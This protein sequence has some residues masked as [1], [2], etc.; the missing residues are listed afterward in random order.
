MILICYALLDSS[1]A[2]PELHYFRLTIN[3]FG[4][5]HLRRH[6]RKTFL[7]HYCRYCSLQGQ[8]K[9]GMKNY[10]FLQTHFSKQTRTLPL[11]DLILSDRNYSKMIWLMRSSVALNTDVLYRC[12]RLTEYL[13]LA[14]NRSEYT[15][16]RGW[17]LSF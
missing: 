5:R 1:R 14:L 9:N 13:F 17:S 10:C 3:V 11:N 7:R 2:D 6:R 15:L 4:H 8:N 16:G 12:Y